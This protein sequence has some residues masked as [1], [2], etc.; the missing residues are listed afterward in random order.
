MN[1]TLSWPKRAH[2]PTETVSSCRVA[3]GGRKE[4]MCERKRLRGKS[5]NRKGYEIFKRRKT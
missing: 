2:K 1:A 3:V 5:T 4:V